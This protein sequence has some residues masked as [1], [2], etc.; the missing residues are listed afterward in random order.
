MFSETLGDFRHEA[1]ND[2]AQA[3]T[4]CSELTRN[5]GYHVFAIGYGGLCL[6]GTD[7]QHRYYTNGTATS[8]ANCSDRIG[9]G[10]RSV[11][12]TLGKDFVA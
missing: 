3:L 5:K 8:A 1:Q 11:V 4:Q 9:T 10:K 12:Y 6:S 2:P 7:A